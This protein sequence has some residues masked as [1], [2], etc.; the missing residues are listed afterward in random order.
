[1][2]S[3]TLQVTWKKACFLHIWGKSCQIMVICIWNLMTIHI[4]V[5]TKHNLLETTHD[6]CTLVAEVIAALDV[7]FRFNPVPITSHFGINSR[8]VFFST[9]HSP[10]YYSNKIPDVSIIC[11]NQR[12]PRITLEER[13]RKNINVIQKGMSE[14]WVNQN[15]VV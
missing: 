1:M 12:S 7:S 8:L 11:Y 3:K 5:H 2:V 4:T 10:A 13:R 9:V 6:V 15:L 14:T